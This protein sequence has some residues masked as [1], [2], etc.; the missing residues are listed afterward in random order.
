MRLVKG[1]KEWIYYLRHYKGPILR[2]CKYMP[3]KK[4]SDGQEYNDFRA[5][6]HDSTKWINYGYC[7]IFRLTPITKEQAVAVVPTARIK[8]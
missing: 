6:Y 3:N 8:L 2:V 4:D 1:K 5:W 7:Y